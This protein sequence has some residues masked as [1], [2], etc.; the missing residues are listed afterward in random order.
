MSS[1]SSIKVA[2]RLRPLNEDESNSQ[3]A[4]HASSADNKVIALRG[5]G[6]AQQRTIYNFDTVFSPSASQREVFDS[7]LKPV[8][9]EVLFGYESTVFAYGQTG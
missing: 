8:I 5:F 4:V 3:P 1:N 2:V 6:K 7:T 9:K